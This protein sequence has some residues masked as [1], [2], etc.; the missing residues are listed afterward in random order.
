[1]VVND[2]TLKQQQKKP[3]ALRFYLVKDCKV[4]IVDCVIKESKGE[5]QYTQ[6]IM[7]WEGFP[8]LANIIIT[9]G[10]D[11]WVQLTS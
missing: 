4:L 11:V 6:A 7:V 5:P 8:G 9:V 1:M 10:Y 3:S 2:Q